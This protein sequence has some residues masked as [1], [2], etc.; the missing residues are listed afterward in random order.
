VALLI[1]SHNSGYEVSAGGIAEALQLNIKT[2]REALTE[3]SSPPVR[4]LAIHKVTAKQWEIYARRDRR[5]THAEHDEFTRLGQKT[6]STTDET[7]QKTDPVETENRTSEQSANRTTKKTTENTKEKTKE[8][9]S[10]PL[11]P[12]AAKQEVRGQLR[13]LIPA[14][15][16][17][18]LLLNIAAKAVVEQH[19]SLDAAKKALN[20]WVDDD[21]ADPWTLR[22]LITDVTDNDPLTIAR[23]L[24][25]GPDDH[26]DV[27]PLRPFGLWWSEPEDIPSHMTVDEV[28]AFTAQHKREWL[29]D[30]V[31]QLQTA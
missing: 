1:W 5:L 14:G 22:D 8:D 19:V 13:D 10:S 24:L 21:H 30:Q 6:D 3:L 16:H 18:R 23:R 9:S 2:A 15:Q 29:H 26:L 12:K 4:W 11:D 25:D 20:Q 7:V 31:R 27:T 28:H 17:Q